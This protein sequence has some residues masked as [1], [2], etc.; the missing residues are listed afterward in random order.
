MVIVPMLKEDDLIGTITIF[1]KE[2]RAFADKQIALVEN[3]TSKP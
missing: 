3:F 1:R 2:V